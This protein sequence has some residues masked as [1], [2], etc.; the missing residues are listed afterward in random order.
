MTENVHDVES[1]AMYRSLVGAI[2]TRRDI[3]L[4]NFDSSADD[5]LLRFERSPC[6]VYSICRKL[7]G[8]HCLLTHEEDRDQQV[9]NF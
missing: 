1:I 8:S 4:T 2:P 7:K 6:P 3:P 9:D 5:T